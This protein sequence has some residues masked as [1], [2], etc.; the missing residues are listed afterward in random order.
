MIYL[1]GIKDFIYSERFSPWVIPLA[2]IIGSIIFSKLISMLLFACISFLSKRS[3]REWHQPL[4]QVFKK[5]LTFFIAF[6]GFYIAFRI[7]PQIHND[8]S[9]WFLVTKCYRTFIILIVTW[10][11]F[12]LTSDKQLML[13][14]LNSRLNLQ[15]NN[16]LLP[17]VSKTLRFITLTIALLVI[18][19][20]WNF[21]I[22]GLLT[23]L[24]LGGLAFALAAQSTLSNLFGGIVI[25]IDRP[26]VIGDWIETSLATGTVERINFRSVR[27]RTFSQALITV[28]NAS[29]A[30]TPI[31]NNSRMGKRGVSVNI[32]LRFDTSLEKIRNCKNKIKE[33]LIENED[34]DNE[35]IVVVIDNIGAS[36]LNLSI[37]YFTVTTVWIE[38]VEVKEAVY[39]NILTLLAQEKTELAFPTQ[40]MHMESDTK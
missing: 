13:S 18:A 3:K 34:I 15:I 8:T 23:G 31:T 22:S 39:L 10:V 36:T 32:G 11:L 25:L 17:I 28:P 20:E 26:F 5:P 24:G 29:L 1:S 38:F 27:V 19:E 33:M 14:S 21:R 40:T 16:I 6:T 37:L 12:N 35:T 2:V 4:K 7:F 30:N 9:A